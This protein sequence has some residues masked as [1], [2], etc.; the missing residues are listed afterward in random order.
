LRTS[1][2]A[3]LCALGAFSPIGSAPTP[4]L[5]AADAARILE[6]VREPGPGVVVVNVWATWCLPCVE[7]FPDLIRLRKNYLGKGVKVLLVSADFHSERDGALRFLAEQGVDFETFLK[8]GDDMKFIEALCPAWSGAMP[9]TFLYDSKGRLVH[10]REGKITY[11]ILEREVR[12]ALKR[13][14]GTIQGPAKG[15]EPS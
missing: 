15:K 6:A 8:D 13:S 7:E 10:F 9:A 3:A 12:T 5:V 14:P 11:E 4:T 2:L 1:I